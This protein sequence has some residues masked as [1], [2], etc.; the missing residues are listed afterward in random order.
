LSREYAQNKIETG[1]ADYN[2]YRTL[3]SLDYKTPDDFVK[4]GLIAAEKMKG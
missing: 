4:L 2:E 3:F 1:L